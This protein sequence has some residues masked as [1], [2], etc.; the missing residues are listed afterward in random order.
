MGFRT[1][2]KIFFVAFLAWYPGCDAPTCVPSRSKQQ[3]IPK[4]P[5]SVKRLPPPPPF[6]CTADLSGVVKDQTKALA[7]VDLEFYQLIGS[8][9]IFRKKGR[10][11]P[12][13]RFQIKRIPPGAYHAVL[14]KSG[15]A[16]QSL[17]LWLFEGANSISPVSLGP[18]QTLKGIVFDDQVEPVKK[19]QLEAT[20]L[21]SNGT[22][23][24]GETDAKG[25]FSLTGL[26]VGTYR[27]KIKAPGH[28]TQVKETLSIPHPNSV[29]VRLIRIF[30][31]RGQ[32][33]GAGKAMVRFVGSGLWPGRVRHV[34]PNGTFVFHRVPRGMYEAVA[35][36]TAPPWRAS[37][38]L[39][40]IRI[41][42]SKTNLLALELKPAVRLH[43]IVLHDGQGVP[44]AKIYLGQPQSGILTLQTESD[45]EGKFVFDPTQAGAYQLSVWS[46]SFLPVVDQ[47]L[48]LPLKAPLKI[49]LGAGAEIMGMVTDAS[50]YP[51][52]DA[53]IQVLYENRP[54]QGPMEKSLTQGELGVFPG[55][56][57]PIPPPGVEIPFASGQDISPT[58][59]ETDK[60]GVFRLAGLYP[61]TAK[62]VAEHPDYET[63]TSKSISLK[64]AVQQSLA[65]LV[66]KPGCI[67]AGRVLDERGVGLP[68]VRVHA[69][70][71]IKQKMVQTGLAGDFIFH[72][73]SG[74]LTL[75]AKRD[76]Y[77]TASTTMD[78]SNRTR[79]ESDLILEV[80]KGVLTGVVMD[81]RR[82]GV[83]D[84]RIQTRSGAHLRF[85]RS[86]PS[87]RFRLEG[88]GLKSME[89]TIEHPEFLPR[90]LLARAGDD[91]E[92]TLEM[93]AMLSG[94]VE[95]SRTQAPITRYTISAKS[96]KA[97]RRLVVH[98]RDGEF[99][100]SGLTPGQ[101][102]LTVD[103][104][105]YAVFSKAV[106]VQASGTAQGATRKG[107][108]IS[109]VP[110]GKV[111]GIVTDAQGRPISNATVS[112]ASVRTV[113]DGKGQFQLNRVPEGN[114][115]L[116]VV[117]PRGKTQ[118]SDPVSIR[119][120]MLNGPL[121]IIVP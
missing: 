15:Y 78:L 5:S 56:V 47:P 29:S 57:P 42:L 104:Q 105:K 119:S 71:L 64:N 113:T 106:I 19:A 3:S 13:G 80:A 73:L 40:G 12:Q 79:I 25:H 58:I 6:L 98:H 21:H 89:V 45:T 22:K 52:P 96:P 27:L 67:V 116:S 10:T 111:T 115:V 55:P 66:L 31:V 74:V 114:R 84:A 110:A 109:L 38:V 121:R 53:R 97:S 43:G 81:P 50:G 68:G 77:L 1:T 26:A 92:I 86:D 112:T 90:K 11:D 9:H 120:R 46:K 83:A 99:H 33:K 72:G 60:H 94:R 32:V 24:R 28:L 85:T 76:G 59:T 17:T 107:I 44:K 101:I 18:A 61:G 108:V 87:G 48:T 14:S 2:G 69:R 23:C 39:S 16:G 51:V 62:V 88:V 30:D 70:T 41:P 93:P 95:E 49:E 36:S 7:G 37:K 103:A 118:Q 35:F 54:H 102:T 8:K 4:T 20:P 91:L 63:T 117:T 34:E 65:P 75:E 100:L 82:Q